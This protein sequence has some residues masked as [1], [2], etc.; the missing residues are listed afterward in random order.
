MQLF[1]QAQRE[2]LTANFRTNQQQP[3]ETDHWPVVKLFT[4][5]AQATWLL[6][7]LD[8]IDELAFGLCDLGMGFPE[9]GYVS[10]AELQSVRGPLGLPIERD[11]HW[12][13]EGPLTAYAEA[14]RK[15]GGIV[16]L[17]AATP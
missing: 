9:L 3:E 8:P 14:A 2:R 7:E 13:A 16:Q 10:L 12:Q 15:A 4:P 6:S 11:R 17:A 1:T 5:D